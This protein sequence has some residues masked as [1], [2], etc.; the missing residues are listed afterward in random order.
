MYA[1]AD[2]IILGID[3]NLTL[4]MQIATPDEDEESRESLQNEPKVNF[5]P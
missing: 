5:A 4:Y 2:E 3:R 1:I